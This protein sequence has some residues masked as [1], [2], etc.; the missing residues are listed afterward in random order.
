MTYIPTMKAYV[1]IANAVPDSLMPRRLR[2]ARS[3]IAATANSTLC[4]P[5][6]GTAEPM[7][8]IADAIDTAT[9]NT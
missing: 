7:F 6:K 8:D 1:G 5:M 4:W 9:V 2:D 3:R